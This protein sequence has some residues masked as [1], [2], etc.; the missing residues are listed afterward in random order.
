MTWDLNTVSQ[1]PGWLL[2]CNH[3]QQQQNLEAE[4]LAFLLAYYDWQEVLLLYWWMEIL[5]EGRG[6]CCQDL[7]GSL[8]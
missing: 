3:Q 5:L 6:I 8:G 7:A 1:W 2:A 4:D